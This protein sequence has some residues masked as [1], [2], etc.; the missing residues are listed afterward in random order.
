MET[1]GLN[2][3]VPKEQFNSDV[4]TKNVPAS[5]A[6]EEILAEGSNQEELA[7]EQEQPLNETS[8][9]DFSD[10]DA[11]LAADTYGIDLGE[12]DEEEE[13]EE[14]AQTDG[15]TSATPLSPDSLQGKSK[16]QIVNLFEEILKSRPIQTIRKDAEAIK[17]AFYKMHRITVEA[18]R[19]EYLATGADPEQFKP[20]VD[21]S[22]LKLKAL[23]TEYRSKRDVYLSTV[24]NEK[25]SNLKIKL[26]IIEELKELVNSSET[27]LH[28]FN[29]FRTLQNR[30]RESGS[31]P[32]SHIKDLWETYHLHVENFYNFIK[33]NKELR[34]LD[35]KKNYE[36]KLQLCESAEALLLEP[37]IVTAFHKLQ[38]LH[39]LWRECG[40]VASEYKEPLWERFKEASSK[41]NKKHQEHFD[42]I[43][44]DQHRN[45][46]LKSGLCAKAEELIVPT[47][48]SRKDWENASN[49]L[50]DIQKIWKTIGFAPKKDNTKIYERFRHACD[51]FFD[52][53]REFYLTSKNEMENNLQA[54]IALCMQ[55]EAFKENEEWKKTTEEL[56]NLQKQWKTIGA[57]PRKQSDIVW[58]RFRA[59]CDDFFSRKSTY[60][61]GLDNKYDG[62]LEA[63]RALLEEIKTFDIAA[64]P[65]G[66]DALKD[67]QR[68]WGEIGFVPM[69]EK[70]AIAAEYRVVIDK[71]FAALHGSDKDRK[72]ERF[73]S[74]IK[75]NGGKHIRN[76]REK[77]FSRMHQIEG[78]ITLLEN[79]IGFFAKSK[80]S[81]SF[82]G[83]VQRKIEKAKEE[84]AT[85]IEKIKIIDAEG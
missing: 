58:R 7:A 68:R 28:T 51:N 24:E 3:S 53:K 84:L 73:V 60:F 36:A 13:E 37:S 70:D 49:E 61:A 77:L 26:Q 45:L 32:K 72:M 39:D 14:P 40:P 38:K 2:T 83:E 82:I 43:K 47:P 79:N 64:V 35:L 34:D 74:R 42:S 65:N 1:N 81:D 69:K 20:S 41:I 22:E 18:E 29:A 6:Q 21:Q 63:K 62:N 59:A 23:F 33:I 12:D 52:K 48:A 55:A 25:E 44:E 75:D 67:F 9:V 16:E 76:E 19:K 8:S 46:E 27:M 54:K 50:I 56:I 80:N 15:T 11:S 4:E 78:D 30:W 10:E 57:V 31:V 66:F 85:I 5:V 17:I 71:H